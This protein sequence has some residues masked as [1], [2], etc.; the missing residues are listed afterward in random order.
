[1][2]AKAR[3]FRKSCQRESGTTTGQPL[4][5]LPVGFIIFFSLPVVCRTMADFTNFTQVFSGQRSAIKNSAMDR[6]LRRFP[7]EGS[8]GELLFDI[9]SL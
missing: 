2:L 6:M 5:A 9:L 1:M 7:T 8:Y 3:G 4:V